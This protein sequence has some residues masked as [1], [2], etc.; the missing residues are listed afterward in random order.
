MKR[1]KRAFSRIFQTL[2][3]PPK[4]CHVSSIFASLEDFDSRFVI[5]SSL[6]LGWLGCFVFPFNFKILSP[7]FFK[8]VYV[9]WILT[10]HTHWHKPVLFCNIW[11]GG[12][13]PSSA[14]PLTHTTSSAAEAD[15]PA[16]LPLHYLAV[17]DLP[18]HGFNLPPIFTLTITIFHTLSWVQLISSS[19][20][21]SLTAAFP[22]LLPNQS[23]HLCALFSLLSCQEFLRKLN[24]HA[25][26][27]C[28]SFVISHV[29]WSQSCWAAGLLI[30]TWQVS[31]FHR[32]AAPATPSLG[33]HPHPHSIHRP[34]RSLSI[35]TENLQ[36]IRYETHPVSFLSFFLHMCI[37][38]Y[39]F[40]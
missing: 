18:S 32:A 37:C 7:L 20:W 6:T 39:I 29:S 12:I 13:L 26:W 23:C 17:S 31:P 19:L 22:I 21:P 35:T 40:I 14:A 27:L 33:A 38:S 10:L 5:F 4:A 34:H 16:A 28:Y 15:G 24:N 9:Y 36:A 2:Q 8:S 11:N 30:P 3:W 25:D 1:G